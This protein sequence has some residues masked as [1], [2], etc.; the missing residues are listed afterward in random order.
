MIKE[1]KKKKIYS[2]VF[3]LIGA[4]GLY[5]SNVILYGFFFTSVSFYLSISFSL[6]FFCLLEILRFSTFRRQLWTSK[7]KQHIFFL[8]NLGMIHGN[9]RFEHMFRFW[10]QYLLTVYREFSK[11]K[12]HSLHYDDTVKINVC[13]KKRK[14]ERKKRKTWMVAIDAQEDR[15]KKHPTKRA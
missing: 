9:V 8:I 2:W 7:L 10:L 12:S 15:R 6:L 11:L 5:Y 3:H 14:E 13:D 4:S 1:K